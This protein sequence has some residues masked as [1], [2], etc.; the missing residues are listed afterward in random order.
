MITKQVQTGALVAQRD[1]TRPSMEDE[2]VHLPNGVIVFD[3]HASD[4]VV[5]FLANQLRQTGWVQ[6]GRE[7]EIIARISN[8]IQEPVGGS[9]MIAAVWDGRGRARVTWVGDGSAFLMN[10]KTGKIPIVQTVERD[11]IDARRVE[12]V[13]KACMIPHLLSGMFVPRTRPVSARLSNV[14]TTMKSPLGS[15]FA[16]SQMDR[17]SADE[18]AA[19]EWVRIH[20]MHGHEQMNQCMAEG[21]CRLRPHGHDGSILGSVQPTRA[22]G[23]KNVHATIRPLP[24]G[25]TCE[26]I[27]SDPDVVM[28]VTSDGA[29]SGKC[30]LDEADLASFLAN[31]KR[32]LIAKGL[33]SVEQIVN[34]ANTRLASIGSSAVRR[35]KRYNLDPDKL[36]KRWTREVQNATDMVAQWLQTGNRID[37]LSI[38]Q[39][40]AA[41]A[42]LLGSTDNVTIACVPQP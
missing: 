4:K 7:N 3:G 18:D 30:F 25:T 2:V 41:T 35:G 16:Q 19:V 21:R 27:A 15:L 17:D 1:G 10:W 40:A 36:H 37:P 23:D 42:V 24:I 33:G 11:G 22:L 28:I 29:Y 8:A 5:R 32:G 14:L 39:L 12:C 6:S 13:R 20:A 34:Q 31:P 26:W 38:T 9:T